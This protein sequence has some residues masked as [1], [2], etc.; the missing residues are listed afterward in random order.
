MGEPESPVVLNLPKAIE[1]KLPHETLKFGV[2]EEEGSDF[3]LHEMG[4][5]D[6]NVALGGVP[7]DDVRVGR[8]LNF[9]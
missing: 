5:K 4:I 1:I 7:G 2:P 9:K 6:V 8:E 3:C